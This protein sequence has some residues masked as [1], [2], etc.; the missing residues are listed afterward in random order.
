MT[1][2]R[3]DVR[4]GVEVAL[5]VFLLMAA[6]TFPGR[7]GLA[8]RQGD[9]WSGLCADLSQLTGLTALAIVIAIGLAE[10]ARWRVTLLGG[11]A[12]ALWS[13]MITLSESC[14]LYTSPS[15]RDQRG[16][17]MPSSA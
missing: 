15:P 12:V 16:S 17:R 6:A 9:L 11:A 7:W 8:S 5:R 4:R 14:L 13:A 10:R 2:V 1:S 3:R